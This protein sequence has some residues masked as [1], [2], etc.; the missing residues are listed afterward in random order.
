MLL[1]T[2][3]G[4]WSVLLRHSPAALREALTGAKHWLLI[5]LSA[6]KLRD[7]DVWGTWRLDM[8]KHACQT[9]CHADVQPRAK[10]APGL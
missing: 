1:G 6:S 9:R 10:S 7:M 2:I 5:S 3:P 8:C 4:P